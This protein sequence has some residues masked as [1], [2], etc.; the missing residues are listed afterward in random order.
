[1]KSVVNYYVTT[2]NIEK[3]GRFRFPSFKVGTC[4]SELNDNNIL[5]FLFLLMFYWSIFMSMIILSSRPT[6]VAV[7]VQC[8]KI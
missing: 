1:M 4:D 3:F 7:Y 2:E 5:H 6:V 8:T